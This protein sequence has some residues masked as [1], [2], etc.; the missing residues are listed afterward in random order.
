MPRGRRAREYS[1]DRLRELAEER[2]YHLARL[3]NIENNIRM[4]QEVN[5]KWD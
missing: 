1:E 5:E 3:E 2:E 4:M